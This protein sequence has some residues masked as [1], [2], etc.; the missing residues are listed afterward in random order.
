MKLAN[1]CL[2]AVVWEHSRLRNYLHARLLGFYQKS[3]TQR[4]WGRAGLTAALAPPRVAGTEI[5]CYQRAPGLKPSCLGI[6]PWSTR[7]KNFLESRTEV[8]RG[9]WTWAWVIDPFIAWFRFLSDST[10]HEMRWVTPFFSFSFSVSSF[11][12]YKRWRVESW[13][14]YFLFSKVFFLYRWNSWAGVKL[15]HEFFLVKKM[16]GRLSTNVRDYGFHYNFFL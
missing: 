7:P 14:F 16:K 13:D 3:G 12:T 5:F 6:T 2:R 11:L 8:C 9:P 15:V 10:T 1:H 4:L